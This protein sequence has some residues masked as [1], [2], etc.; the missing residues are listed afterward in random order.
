[1]KRDRWVFPGLEDF[2]FRQLQ[3]QG[4]CK[5]DAVLTG[6]AT[7]NTAGSQPATLSLWGTGQGP[8]PP[9]HDGSEM[10]V[11]TCNR[12]ALRNSTLGFLV[13]T[14]SQLAGA[15]AAMQRLASL[16]FHKLGFFALD[17]VLVQIRETVGTQ[18]GRSQHP[19]PLRANSL[20]GHHC[21]CCR[22]PSFAK[23]C[24]RRIRSAR[25]ERRTE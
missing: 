13:K 17:H 4:I 20:S 11:T 23:T 15:A 25:K 12:G 8:G 6:L 3:A 9:A 1:M 19:L 14:G 22:K 24:R 5:P 18:L 10:R 2:H 7:R 21:C 16:F